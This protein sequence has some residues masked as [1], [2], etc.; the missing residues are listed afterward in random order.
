MKPNWATKCDQTLSHRPSIHG[1]HVKED[2]NTFGI[3]I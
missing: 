3:T 1:S 2:K